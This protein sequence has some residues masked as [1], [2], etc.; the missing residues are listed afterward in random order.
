[1]LPTEH[2][3]FV[4][5]AGVIAIAVVGWLTKQL[6]EWLA[7]F[8]GLAFAIRARRGSALRRLPLTSG[9]DP[10]RLGLTSLY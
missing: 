8:V 5:V 2:L 10:A 7:T 9:F 6:L 4:W 3:M 1:M